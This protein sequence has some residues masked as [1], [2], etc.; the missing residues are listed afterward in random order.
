MQGV[1]LQFTVWDWK[2]TLYQTAAAAVTI[3]PAAASRQQAWSAGGLRWRNGGCKGV[4]QCCPMAPVL[5][6]HFFL[7]MVSSLDQDW[8]QHTGLAR[9]AETVSPTSCRPLLTS[10]CDLEQEYSVLEERGGEK[11][12]AW[13]DNR[14]TPDGFGA[15]GPGGP[16]RGNGWLRLHRPH[17]WWSA[18]AVEVKHNAG[19]GVIWASRGGGSPG[20]CQQQFSE[21]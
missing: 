9:R 12:G 10:A 5:A 2:W 11:R 4:H 13:A 15:R 1:Q 21:G 14:L 16:G 18:I 3:G 7:V 19:P 17:S 8:T 20:L 6:S